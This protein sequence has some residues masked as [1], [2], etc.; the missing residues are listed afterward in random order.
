MRKAEAIPEGVAQSPSWAC[1][2]EKDAPGSRSPAHYHEMDAWVRVTDGAM[3]FVGVEDGTRFA[4]GKGDVFEVPAGEVHAVEIGDGGV[5]Y[6]MWTPEEVGAGFTKALT[7]LRPHGPG[8]ADAPLAEL[9][10]VSFQ[11]P[12]LEDRM[13]ATRAELE[14]LMHPDLAFRR[15]PGDVVG[16]DAYLAALEPPPTKQPTTRTRVGSSGLEILHVTA[17][18]V[19]AA[20]DVHVLERTEGSYLVTRSKVRNLRTFV[21]EDHWKCRLWVNTPA[22][23]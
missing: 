17:K 4:L 6:E 9:V 23:G 14:A 18:S 20:I 1:S 8:I 3:T 15:V 10:R 5:T 21:R 19:V 13:P 7:R 16:R 12:R 2:V 22:D 11:I